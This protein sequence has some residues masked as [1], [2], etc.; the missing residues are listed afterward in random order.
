MNHAFRLLAIAGLVVLLSSPAR[1]NFTDGLL[2]AQRGDY[3]SAIAAWRPLA[4]AGDAAAQANL[5]ILYEQGLGVEKDMAEAAV[6]YEKAAQNGNLEAQFHIG[7]LYAVGQGIPQDYT[8]AYTWFETAASRGDPRAEY[9]LGVLLADGLGRLPAPGQAA[10]WFRKAAEQ[11][12]AEAQ[13]RYA[14][15]MLEGQGPEN[16]PALLSRYLLAAA[17]VGITDAQFRLGQLLLKGMPGIPMNATEGLRWLEAGAEQNYIPAIVELGIAYYQGHGTPPDFAK[18]HTLFTK[19]AEAGRPSA[20][21]NL[22]LMSQNGQGMPQDYVQAHFWCNVAAAGFPSG[23][24][25]EMA[26]RLRDEI[27]ESLSGKSLEKAQDL[28]KAWW[29]KHQEK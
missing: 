11:D 27:G 7:M 12:Y 21:F 23:T 4:S 2:A 25:R 3:P 10:P 17:N 14:V 20:Q 29:E 9:N 5:G 18:A 22:C 28:A 26:I 13:Y 24:E 1:A 15:M 6:W 8:K 16:D 19:A